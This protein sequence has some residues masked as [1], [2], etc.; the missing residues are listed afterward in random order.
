MKPA[1]P[2]QLILLTTTLL[3]GA[4][5]ATPASLHQST[6]ASTW[7]Y[8]ARH[9]LG[10]VE[11]AV[12][13]P[14][15]PNYSGHSPQT[16]ILSCCFLNDRRRAVNSFSKIGRLFSPFSCV[17]DARLHLLILY[18]LLMRGNFHP[19]PGPI[20]PCSVCA[21]SVNWRGKSVQCC[22]CFKWVYL[23]CS[24]LS[25]SKFRTLGSS[26][27]WNCPPCCIPAYNTVT[28]STVTSTATP[29]CNNV[30]S[31]RTPLA[32][33]PPLF[34]LVPLL[35]MQHSCPTLAFKSFIPL[36]PILS[37]L[38]L[39]SHHRILLRDV[40]LR[41]LFPLPLTL[42]GFFNG[43]LVIFQLG[44]LNCYIFFRPILL[45]IS[46]SRNLILTHFPLF[47]SVDSLLCDL[48]A[49]TPGLAFSLVMPRTL[50]AASSFS[51]GR[52]YPFQNFLLILP[53]FLRWTPTLVL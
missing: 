15:G 53:F 26:H 11:M 47:G 38:P 4:L 23:R 37:L 49:S 46:V 52:A 1:W 43:M 30:S 5:P 25:L 44:A 2:A 24:L 31:L 3:M 10:W 33:I 41:L 19:N 13:L 50:A 6:A 9:R 7:W 48:I 17:F 21:E 22:T 32:C 27:S 28:S 36:L 12:G 40:L 18:L 16:I 20:F 35:L 29:H 8:G 39:L 14:E 45:T 34:Y 51:S 42:S